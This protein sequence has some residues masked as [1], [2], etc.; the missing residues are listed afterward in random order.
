MK[1]AEYVLDTRY[2][3]H[4]IDQKTTQQALLYQ[5]G[6]LAVA[7]SLIST[8]PTTPLRI[9]KNLRVCVD[10]HNALKIMSKIVGRIY[11]QI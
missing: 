5:S 10:C 7:Y 3:L 4:D 1:D 2:V 9:I 6:R 8:P 11:C